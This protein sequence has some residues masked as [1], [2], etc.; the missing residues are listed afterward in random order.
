MFASSAKRAIACTPV[1]AHNHQPTHGR[2]STMPLTGTNF[3]HPPPATHVRHTGPPVRPTRAGPG[4]RGGQERL[5][6]SVLWEVAPET[7]EILSTSYTKAVISSRAALTY[8]EAQALIDTGALPSATLAAGNAEAAARLAG[9]IGDEPLQASM[10]GAGQEC[11]CSM[12]AAAA[13]AAAA[14]CCISW[15]GR[16]GREG[17]HSGGRRHCT[18]VSQSWVCVASH[19]TPPHPSLAT[20]RTL[21]AS[22][23]P[24]RLHLQLL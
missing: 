14:S 19:P 24:Q 20:H 17:T 23:P 9:F 8:A 22:T 12:G 15:G 18:G 2:H 21:H 11:S 13:A 3:P 1:P 7:A 4:S 16:R 6:F 10:C 5:T